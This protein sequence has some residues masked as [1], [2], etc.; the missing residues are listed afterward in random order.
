MEYCHYNGTVQHWIDTVLENREKDAKVVLKTC[1]D[2]IEYGYK[3]DDPRLIGFGCY[4]SGETYYGLNDGVHFLDSMAEALTYLDRAGEWELTARCYNYLGIWAEGRGNPIVALDYYLN[5][6]K[7]CELHDLTVIDAVIHVNLGMQYL[8]CEHYKDSEEAFLYAYQIL[9]KHPEEPNYEA[10]M[11]CICGN[12]A[13]GLIMQNRMGDAKKYLDI[14]HNRFGNSADM[15]DLLFISCVD[16][17]YYHK[18]GDEKKRDAC[19]QFI[20]ENIPDNLTVLDF[21]DDFYR[22]CLILL[23]TEQDESFWRIVEVLEPQV[24]N[25]GIVNLH[26]KVLSLKMKYYRRHGQSAE[27]LQAAGLYYELSERNEDEKKGML[28]GVITLKNNLEHMRKARMKVEHKN[29]ILKKQSE[30]DP[31]TH[32]AN[33]YRLREYSEEVFRYSR[34]HQIPVAVEILDVDYFKEYNDNYGHQAGDNCLISIAKVIKNLAEEN[35]A[36]SARYGGDEFVVI[37][38]NISKEEITACAEK[39]RKRVLELEIE[40]QY[41][42]ALPLVTVS[43]GLCWGIPGENNRGK[44]FLHAADNMLY[45]VKN[46]SR[47][48]YCIGGVDETEDVSFGTL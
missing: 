16:I 26:L 2:I 40:H 48:N 46:I 7:I 21:F 42:K 22:C 18:A 14:V 31:L 10:Y 24:I 1:D 47:N 11:F 3:T 4:Y 13:E 35:H 19:I 6:I 32:L 41:S 37:Y 9:E 36:F 33:R 23:D 15:I 43:Q 45:R 28:S 20:Y 38:V 8:E 12:M 29:V 27:Y 34:Q 25:V 17:A 39:L 30:Q 5:G 44:D